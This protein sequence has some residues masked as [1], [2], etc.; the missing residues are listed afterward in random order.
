MTATLV[1]I[2][3]P[4]GKSRQGHSEGLF[5][6]LGVCYGQTVLAFEIAVCPQRGVISRGNIP[7]LAEKPVA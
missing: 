3:L 7:G 4:V 6:T 1:Q 5:D 2:L